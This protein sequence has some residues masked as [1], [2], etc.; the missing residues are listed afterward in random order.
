M[1]FGDSY[2]HPSSYEGQR[3][4]AQSNLQSVQRQQATQNAQ[5][6]Q[7]RSQ[8]MQQQISQGIMTPTGEE[9]P[10]SNWRAW[11]DFVRSNYGMELQDFQQAGSQERYG[12]FAQTQGIAQTPGEIPTGESGMPDR[13]PQ[14]P[15]E[16]AMFQWQSGEVA[17]QKNEQLLER[18]MSA[19]EYALGTLKQGGPGSIYE[20]TQPIIGQMAQTLNTSEYSEPDFSFWLT[21]QAYGR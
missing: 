2:V 12:A 5:M 20:A 11:Q 18:A 7:Q 8:P 21:P 6:M 10:T 14:T 4:Q 9:I 3:Q 13:P 19:Y 16:A 15:Q 1:A 17:R